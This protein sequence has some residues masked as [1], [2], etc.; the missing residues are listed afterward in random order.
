[1]LK[2]FNYCVYGSVLVMNLL[3]S[4]SSIINHKYHHMITNIALVLLSAI[5]LSGYDEFYDGNI[6]HALMFMLFIFYLTAMSWI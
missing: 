1:M 6:R 5:I 4:I 3:L 2:F